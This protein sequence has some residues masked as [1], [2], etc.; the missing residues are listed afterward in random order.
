MTLSGGLPR[1][2]SQSGSFDRFR[3]LTA[4]CAPV[5][6]SG[7]DQT[8]ELHNT[9]ADLVQI[10]VA[11]RS[12]VE[13]RLLRE[14]VASEVQLVLEEAFTNIVKYAHRDGRDDHP[15]TL[16]L[17]TTPGWLDIELI[18]NGVAFDPFA[19]AVD[20]LDRPFEERSDGL[21][22]LPLIKALVD[23]FSYARRNG[24][25]HLFLRKRRGYTDTFSGLPV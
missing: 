14:E 19:K 11:V 23:E 2:L 3:A 9:V 12:L 24:H 6:K 25:N 21:M 18:D 22:G 20:Q 16:R 7:V 1:R 13:D 8:L 17:R 5:T 10:E 15:V 4:R